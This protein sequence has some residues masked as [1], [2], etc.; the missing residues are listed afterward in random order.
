MENILL[1]VHG[2]IALALVGV[3][4]L[5]RSEGGALGIGGNSGGGFMS[6]RGKANLLTR[7]TTILAVA[8]MTMTL[9]LAVIHSQDSKPSS[10]L[11]SHSNLLQEQPATG[12]A[13]GNDT[14]P[15][16]PVDN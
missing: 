6:A 11:D 4:L 14:Q 7:T 5:Q 15:S 12:P 13:T 1:A 9:I 2:L 8:F 16:V 10:I 3:V